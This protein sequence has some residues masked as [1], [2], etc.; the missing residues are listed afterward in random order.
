MN[1]ETATREI[2]VEV[3]Y[4]TPARQLIIPLRVPVGTT[5]LEAVKLSGIVEEFPQIDLENDPMGIFSEILDGKSRPTPAEYELQ[6]RDRVEIY[7]PLTIDPKA[8]RRARAN[9]PESKA[10]AKK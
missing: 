9:S 6:I 5:A 1:E 2:P 8:A 4:A 10:R 3:A 7:R